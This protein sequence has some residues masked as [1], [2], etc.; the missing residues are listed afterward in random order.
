MQGLGE[1]LGYNYGCSDKKFL[2]A[3]RN[4]SRKE[5]DFSYSE[6]RSFPAFIKE[7]KLKIIILK[8]L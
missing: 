6:I 1:F 5:Q 3:S 8:F 4:E 2:G 7:M